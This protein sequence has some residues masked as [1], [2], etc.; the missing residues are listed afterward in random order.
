MGTFKAS[1]I[2]PVRNGAG[3]LGDCLAALEA[4]SVPRAQY[5]IIVVD[6]GSCDASASVAARFGVRVLTQ[7]ARGAAAARNWGAA[8]ATSDIL[9]FTDA[10]AEPAHDWIAAMLAAFEDCRVAGAKGV[11]L[12]RQRA[13]VARFVQVEYEEKYARLRRADAI[14]FVDTYSAGYRRQVFLANGGFDESFPAASVE[15]QEFSFRLANRG[16]RLVFAPQAVVYHRHADSLGA[17]ARKKF[18]IGFWKVHVHTRHPNKLWRDAH[19]PQ[20]LKAQ[21][22]L[23][24]MLAVTIAATVFDSELAIAAAVLALGWLASAL[25]LTVFIARRDP[26]IARI[27]PGMI[28][29]RA[30]ALGLGLV[31]GIGGEIA[32]SAAVKRA[33]D[34]IGAVAGLILAAPL[35]LLIALAIKLDSPGPALFVQDRAGLDGRPFK[36]L[37]FRSMV[38]GA[39][40]MLA[41]VLGRS[42]VPPP[43]FKM[44]ADPR[45]TRVGRVLRRFS[46]DELPQFVNVLKGEMSL[47]GPRP[48]ETRVVAQYDAWQRRRLSVKPGMTGPM[49]TDGRGALPLD[50]RVR[51]E[52]AYIEHYSLWQD[53]CLLA[54]TLPAVLRGPGAY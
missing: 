16:H 23:L 51:L 54:K 34:I 1:V 31:A 18:R 14:D 52:L 15:D 6:D 39:E 37:K 29:V 49:Q 22:A 47:V 20:T 12:T 38:V 30:A 2:V 10:D 48:E 8:H 53:F 4:Q 3:T 44:R 42:Q 43:V 27:A 40:E 32:R 26:P 35:M 36:M 24:G 25:P 41:S 28:L 21:I 45:V 9:L 5:E 11:Y 17:Y 7:P 33:M 19:T 13:W 46:L 50:E